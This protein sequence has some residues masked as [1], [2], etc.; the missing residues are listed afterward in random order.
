MAK[1]PIFVKNLLSKSEIIVFLKRTVKILDTVHVL[2]NIHL[3]FN[4]S[5][6]NHF[7]ISKQVIKITRPLQGLRVESTGKNYSDHEALAA[8]ISFGEDNSN[9]NE[10]IHPD[11]KDQL[12]Q[13]IKNEL[14]LEL[15]TSKWWS[16]LHFIGLS[17]FLILSLYSL[18][19]LLNP[20][21]GLFWIMFVIFHFCMFFVYK[22]REFSLKA[23]IQ[24]L[25]DYNDIFN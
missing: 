15:K 23:K 18:V 14:G 16:I 1:I 22:E 11:E 25:F 13:E 6:N 4:H 20:L 21:L 9:K 10:V 17:L 12:V 7:S 8:E 5:K 24:N 3:I 19:I 2:S